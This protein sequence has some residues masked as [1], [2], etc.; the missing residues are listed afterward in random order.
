[1]QNLGKS[2]PETAKVLAGLAELSRQQGKQQLALELYHQ[3]LLVYG[4]H[5]GQEHPETILVKNRY[6]LCQMEITTEGERIVFN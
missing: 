2:H 1:V 6:A 5:L 4:E 3:V